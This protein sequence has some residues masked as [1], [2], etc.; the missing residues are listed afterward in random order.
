MDW[1]E[2]DDLK[3]FL[4]A[5]YG[6]Q[7]NQWPMTESMFDLTFKLISESGSCTRAMD[8]IPRP[9]PPTGRPY[10]WLS[11]HIRGLFLR[12]LKDNKKQYSICLK[13]TALKM[14]GEFH[15]AASGV[16]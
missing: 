10:Q 5:L 4:V 12:E 6:N 7:A 8:L 13:A 2:R 15:M 14:A 3:E 1:Y 16:L 11:K 9:A